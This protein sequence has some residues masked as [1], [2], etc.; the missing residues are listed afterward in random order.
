MSWD[1]SPSGRDYVCDSS[2]R[3]GL[4]RGILAVVS[5]LTEIRDAARVF[6]ADRDWQQL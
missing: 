6:I 4:R 3:R 5:D 2:Q 1:G